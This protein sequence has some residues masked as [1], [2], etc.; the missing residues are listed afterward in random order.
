M[1]WGALLHAMPY[2]S[3]AREQLERF[4]G[5]IM[6]EAVRAGNVRDSLS[7]REL[8]RYALAAITAS[9]PNTAALIRLV[10][11]IMRGVGVRTTRSGE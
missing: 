2:M 10:R 6:D 11:L 7:S 3:E 5:E 8:A 9:V 1:R 4:V